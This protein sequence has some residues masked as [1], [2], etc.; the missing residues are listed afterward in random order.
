MPRGWAGDP[1]R[2]TPARSERQPVVELDH[3][4]VLR[5]EAPQCI[6][7][8]T[9]VEVARVDPAPLLSLPDQEDRGAGTILPPEYRIPDE[10][11]DVEVTVG[12][13]VVR[14]SVPVE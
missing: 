3:E 1:G 13:S 11:P 14:D 5:I 4:H 12:E 2:A 10:G 8:T 6:E 7:V 9:E